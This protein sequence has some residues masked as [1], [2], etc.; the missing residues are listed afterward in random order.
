MNND[1]DEAKLPPSLVIPRKVQQIEVL[2]GQVFK[3]VKTQ[4][5]GEYH[6]LRLESVKSYIL[7]DPAGHQAWFNDEQ[8]VALRKQY[9]NFQFSTNAMKDL[10][11][12]VRMGLRPFNVEPLFNTDGFTAC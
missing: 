7:V 5:T 10:K 6:L 4:A 9:P 8:I 1:G 11:R 12:M 3:P 2:G